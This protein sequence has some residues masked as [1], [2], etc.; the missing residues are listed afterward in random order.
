MRPLRGGFALGCL[1][2]ALSSVDAVP[3]GTAQFRN[4][5]A[6]GPHAAGFRVVNQYDYSRVFQPQIDELGHPWAGERARPIQTFIWYPAEKTSKPTM[7]WGDYVALDGN[8][9]SFDR[10]R[11]IPQAADYFKSLL[12]PSYGEPTR[13]TRDAPPSDGH[14]P[15]VVY[16]PSFTSGAWE[17]VEF[18]EYLASWG[19]V[20]IAS[21]GM[22]VGYFSTHDLA[23]VEAQAQDIR[24]LVGYAQSLTDIDPGHIAVVGFSWGGL[25]NLFAAAADDRIKALVDLDGSIRY[26]PG[27]VK[28][29][30]IDPSRVRIPL[31]YFKSQ[32]S[33]E[34]QAELESSFSAAAGPSVLNAWTGGDFYSVEMLR[35]VH[36]EFCSIVFRNSDFWKYE[37]DRLQPADFTRED[38]IQSYAYVEAYTKAFLDFYLKQRP[39]GL[40]FLHAA[41]VQNG[42]APHFLGIKTRAGKPRAF[43]FAD[44]RVAVATAGFERVAEAYAETRKAHPEFSLSAGDLQKWAS[45]LVSIGH[46]SEAI[47][48]A[49]FALVN[50][51]SA[52]SY[53]SLGTAYLAARRTDDAIDAFKQALAVKPDDAVARSALGHLDVGIG[54]PGQK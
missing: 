12:A 53:N 36:P 25:A 22:G 23:G 45:D 40:A 26:W 39:D 19:Y 43:D 54:D 1:L 52:G 16:A 15:A 11:A 8:Q 30:G 44:F 4:E 17:N 42:V 9:V 35:I 14:F 41:P 51:T 32:D 5:A 10:P 33:L 38:G 21:P 27:L 49:I 50:E 34:M 2:V 31:L 48:V 37:F 13:G 6:A 7:T 3:T 24:F 20:V 47:A 28:A 29:A 18:C 46:P